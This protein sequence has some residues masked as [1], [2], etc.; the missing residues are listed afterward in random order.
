VAA[1]AARLDEAGWQRFG[2]LAAEQR[3]R[4]LVRAFLITQGGDL[5]IPEPISRA[6]ED[7]CRQIT[8]RILFRQA[9]AV[10]IVQALTAANIPVIV[11]KGAC[12]ANLVYRDVALREMHDLDLL[13]PS[14]FLQA[15]VDAMLGRGYES[16]RRSSV[17][18]DASVRHHVAPL[19]KGVMTVEIHWNIT[20]PGEPYTI[21][22]AELWSRAM[23]LP[24]GGTM[25]RSLSPE[26]LLL[27]LCLHTSY[28]H[29][30]ECGLR[31]SCDIAALIDRYGAQFDWDA[32]CRRSLQWRWSKGVYVALALA[33]RLVGAKVPAEVLSRLQGNDSL[34]AVESANRLL[35]AAPRET[36]A[37]TPSLAP[38]AA[39]ASWSDRL[40]HGLARLFPSPAAFRQAYS[41]QPRVLVLCLHYVLRACG[42]FWRHGPSAVRLVAGTDPEARA[43]AVRRDQMRQWLAD[44]PP[45]IRRR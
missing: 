22:P 21:D 17:A 2:A 45:A 43:L 37:F 28:H 8:A 9:E 44:S 31:P 4:P 7:Q 24:I 5:G 35:W 13:V 25:A 32:V 23:P 6:L 3:V 42:L 10:R 30:F 14:E 19:V 41:I 38:L 18:V 1:A 39:H 20:A 34:H 15:A 11:L 33:Q 12:L 40:R 16:L 29:Q 26:D 36:A 27:H